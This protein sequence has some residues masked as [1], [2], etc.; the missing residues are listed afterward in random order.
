[1]TP[2]AQTPRSRPVVQWWLIVV[3]IMLVVLPLAL[4][5]NGQFGGADDAARNA[6]TE[7][8]PGYQPWFHPIWKP[9]SGEIESLLFAIQAGLGAG[10]VGYV[11]GLK[12]GAQQARSTASRPDDEPSAG[13]ARPSQP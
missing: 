6:V 8:R 11:L 12:R 2:P 5:R 10:F 1:M 4:V 13:K 7:L 9:P 3:V